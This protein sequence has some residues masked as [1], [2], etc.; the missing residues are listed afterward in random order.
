MN[1]NSDRQN[2]ASTSRQEKLSI[3]SAILGP[4]TLAKLKS[5]QPADGP[6]SSSEVTE[7]DPSRAEW[8]RN[9]LLERFRL[10]AEENVPSKDE[11]ISDLAGEGVK[12]NPSQGTKRVT[13]EDRLSGLGM[14]SNLALEHPAVIAHLL[15]KMP[16]GDRVHAMKALPGPVA[17]AVLRR[18]R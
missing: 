6:A 17:R 16:R 9:R 7:P 1:Q 15:C 3:L 5:E 2:K 18:I 4:E 8:H 13:I 12:P 10:N 14:P 11:S